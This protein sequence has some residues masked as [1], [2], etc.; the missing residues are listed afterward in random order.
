M[1]AQMTVEVQRELPLDPAHD[2]TAD[3]AATSVRIIRW[4][5]LKYKIGGR[6]LTSITRDEK[7]GKFPKR[8]RQGNLV[9]WLEHEINEYLLKLPRGTRYE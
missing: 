4:P 8:V 9:G 1:R 2:E 7:S 6:S 3:L 5:E